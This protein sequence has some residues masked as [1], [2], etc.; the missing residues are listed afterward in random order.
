MKEFSI[1]KK[2]EL[3]L[4]LQQLETAAIDL[5]KARSQ[6]DGYSREKAEMRL[7][8]AAKQ[9]ADIEATIAY[10]WLKATESDLDTK[11][12]EAWQPSLIRSLSEL[13]SL[14]LQPHLTDITIFPPGSWA[15]EFT[16]TLWK[17]YISRDD[18]DFYI[19]DN[20]VKK[21][22]VFKV[23]YV[24]PSQWKGALRS[25][26]M[27]ELIAKLKCGTIDEQG[28]IDERLQYYRFFGNEKDGTSDFLN[29]AL[30]RYLVGEPHQDGQGNQNWEKSFE[31]KVKE[32]GE[33]FEF[34]LRERCY[35]QGDVE[36]YRG[37][38]HFYPTFFNKIGLEVINPH[39]RETGAGSQP[40][41]F[42]CV[43]GIT[44]DKDGN[45]VRT[46][47][48][49]I[50][51][52]VPLGGQELAPEEIKEQEV[53]DLKLLARGIKAMITCYGFGAKTSSGFGV[54]EV[55]PTVA[56]IKPEEFRIHWQTAWERTP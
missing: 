52:Y 8:E 27:H 16:F 26:M 42:E 5:E 24:A 55:D 51:L 50:L 1:F 46:P 39:N 17:P 4:H 49:F 54:G 13:R 38:L 28:F 45:E 6:R 25:A 23:P 9:C 33:V 31:A 56:T 2:G 43:P 37:C 35:L 21:E 34:M 12:R 19:L 11:V 10:L 41:Y 40:I 47:G 32:I 18:T 3:N 36:G 15:I 7:Q 53:E 48:T 20:P 14:N 22:W 30:A 44:K 29:Q